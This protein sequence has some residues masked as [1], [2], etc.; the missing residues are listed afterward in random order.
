MHQYVLVHS[1]SCR[2][3][4]Q[5]AAFLSSCK[6]VVGYTEARNCFTDVCKALENL[7]LVGD[8][9]MESNRWLVRV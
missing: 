6:L 4:K 3:N 5:F 7:L 9:I 2:M 8:L 1:K